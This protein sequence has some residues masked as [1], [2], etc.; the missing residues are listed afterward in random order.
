[1]YLFLLTVAGPP[2]DFDS[3]FNGCS[4][5]AIGSKAY[6]QFHEYVYELTCDSSTSECSWRTMDQ[7]LGLGR[8]NAV[9][10]VL[11]IG[12][13]CEMT[14][15]TTT[16]TEAASE[17]EEL[18]EEVGRAT[19]MAAVTA[20]LTPIITNFVKTIVQSFITAG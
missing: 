4:A 6:M 12:F 17:M 8:Y 14:T 7:Q 9:A 10:M 1:M 13:T 2:T 15:T 11:P 3:G 20:V 5:T 18:A 19:F 16:T